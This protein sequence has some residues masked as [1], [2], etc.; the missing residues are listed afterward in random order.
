MFANIATP[1][2]TRKTRKMFIT[3]TVTPGI[4]KRHLRL[5]FGRF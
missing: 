5:D 4:E 3:V 1:R 2:P